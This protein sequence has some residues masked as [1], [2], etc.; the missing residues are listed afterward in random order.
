M[1]YMNRFLKHSSEL[2]YFIASMHCSSFHK[3]PLTQF[4]QIQSK[5]EHII[6]HYFPFV[7]HSMP[8]WLYAT[9]HNMHGAH[10]VLDFFRLDRWAVIAFCWE[11]VRLA[12]VL[13]RHINKSLFIIWKY[14]MVFC[15]WACKIHLAPY[16]NGS[17]T[18]NVYATHTRTLT[19][20]I[21][22]GN[23]IIRN[24]LFIY[25]DRS[26]DHFG[27]KLLFETT[28]RKMKTP[29]SFTTSIHRLPWVT[30]ELP[31][32]TW[33]KHKTNQ[34]QQR[35]RWL[36]LMC[37]VRFSEYEVDLRSDA[38]IQQCVSLSFSFLESILPICVRVY[39]YFLLSSS[40]LGCTRC[41]VKELMIQPK[42]RR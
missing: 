33:T 8:I 40:S 18:F 35:Q 16:T 36:V 12:V 2:V 30:T 11:C 23:E 3:Y 42:E 28:G 21:W 15:F 39:V 9:F 31:S 19:H 26:N 5:Y 20:R 6:H 37:S 27:I 4:R 17:H 10:T 25:C 7:C 38:S 14:A 41:A 34:Q 24:A 32:S 22:S 29:L 1:R 13:S